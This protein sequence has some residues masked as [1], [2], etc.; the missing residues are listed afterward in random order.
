MP[1]LVKHQA[2]VSCVATL[3]ALAVNLASEK[4]EGDWELTPT[5]FNPKTPRGTTGTTSPQNLE[6]NNSTAM[7]GRLPS[8]WLELS[9]RKV[10][11]IVW[12]TKWVA[13]GNN[14]KETSGFD[15]PIDWGRPWF[16]LEPSLYFDTQTPSKRK[17][18]GCPVESGSNLLGHREESMASTIATNQETPYPSLG[19]YTGS[20]TR[21]PPTSITFFSLVLLE[22]TFPRYTWY[23]GKAH[24]QTHPSLPCQATVERISLAKCHSSHRF[25]G[26]MMNASLVPLRDASLVLCT[27]DELVL[28]L[29]KP[30]CHPLVVV[31][32]PCNTSTF[33][34]AN[35]PKR[36]PRYSKV[37]ACTTH[38]STTHWSTTA[39]NLPSLWQATRF[40]CHPVPLSIGGVGNVCQ[41]A[42]KD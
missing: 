37:W 16:F 25:Y 14:W 24:F 34:K 9:K 23:I 6:A 39:Q 10:L 22:W 19:E 35:D 17:P 36:T 27:F 21:V 3:S 31:K 32:E 29:P 28:D 15:N 4:W 40:L 5:D 30:F 26:H 38:W 11:S 2:A 33:W 8:G 42:F 41:Y 20:E 13:W 7:K 1:N 12:T 18:K